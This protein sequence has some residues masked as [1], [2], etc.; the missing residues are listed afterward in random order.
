MTQPKKNLTQAVCAALAVMA[1]PF[2]TSAHAAIQSNSAVL[3]VQ[4]GTAALPANVRASHRHVA[5]GDSFST[6]AN[7]SLE[8]LL[9][10][11]TSLLLGPS[12]TVTVQE[13]VYDDARTPGGRLI[14]QLHHGR[15]RISG[16][17]ISATGVTRVL[18]S[19][20]EVNLSNASAS[21]TLEGGR[22]RVG[23]LS[24]DQV[25]VT[26][27]AASATLARP[28]FEVIAAGGNVSAPIRSAAETL[29]ADAYAVNPGL[30][31]SS[32]LNSETGSNTGSSA[33]LASLGSGASNQ[34]SF[35]QPLPSSGGGDT[36]TTPTPPA[37]PGATPTPIPPAPGR[38]GTIDQAL[39][40]GNGFGPGGNLGAPSVGGDQGSVSASLG[41]NITQ[42]RIPE[43]ATPPTVPPTD[44]LRTQSPTTNRLFKASGSLVGDLP[45]SSVTVVSDQFEN[46][47][48]PNPDNATTRANLQYTFLQSPSALAIDRVGDE[49]GIDWLGANGTSNAPFLLRRNRPS[50]PSLQLAADGVFS[51]AYFDTPQIDEEGPPA[52]ADQRGSV[53]DRVIRN[54][55]NQITRMDGTVYRLLQTGFGTPGARADDNFFF[56]D[57]RP[58]QA[59]LGPDSLPTG[60][61]TLQSDRPERFIFA[62]GDVDGEGNSPNTNFAVQHFFLSAGF[63]GYSEKAANRGVASGMR[64]FLRNETALGLTLS[65][66]GVLVAGRGAGAVGDE[67]NALLHADFGLSGSGDSQ[68]STISVTIG[69]V[70]YTTRTA[71]DPRDA[72]VSGDRTIGS[73]QDNTVRTGGQARAATL[74][75]SPLFSTAAGG[76]NPDVNMSGRAGYFVFENFDPTAAISASNAGTEKPL[77]AGG[78]TVNYAML[79][80]A[81]ATGNVTATP[82]TTDTFNGFIAG[83][84]E[85]QNGGN[86]GVVQLDSGDTAAGFS[87]QTNATNNRAAASAS[88]LTTT[89][90]PTAL[91]L[92][93][94]TGNATK[95]QSAFIDDKRFAARDANGNVA[96]VSGDLV[97]AGL[98]ASMQ[99]QIANYQHL[100]WGFFFGDVVTTAGAREHAHLASWIAGKVPNAADLPIT[101]T[102]TYGGHAIGNVYSNGSIYTAVGSYANAWNFASR[103]GNVTMNFDNATYTGTTALA[104][105]SASFS[106][107]INGSNRTGAVFGSFVQGGA[108]PAAAQMGRFSINETSSAPYRAS[109]TFGA[110]KQ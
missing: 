22:M 1:A 105:G 52:T 85:Y 41:R 99:S 64:A 35:E 67:Q 17:A 74:I 44:A 38:P 69:D 5:A 15:M 6:R 58:A 94:L 61:F 29:I 65:D 60:V 13:Y 20:G 49:A 90:T 26:Q 77:D 24:G 108:D 59:Q 97:K 107:Q 56:L 103:Q 100:Q 80:L 36:G 25:R 53:L 66:T 109:G 96:L 83:V 102:A 37:P 57:A 98:P 89:G 46:G 12:T 70:Q 40:N 82:R 32:A 87:L 11:G 110:E 51:N 48:N 33:Q 101:G 79:R 3:V 43:A 88:L 72:I 54:P 14:L 34:A 47:N 63:D 31:R 50:G 62:T 106:G 95:G 68:K 92:G 86:I 45:G 16:G 19:A 21:L 39:G 27:G 9:P 93:G 42:N 28:G 2:G 76:G 73:S 18:T 91:T 30:A 10:D 55:S 78:T 4:A 71:T 81:T 7:E 104:T 84:A 8:V 75:G 23:L